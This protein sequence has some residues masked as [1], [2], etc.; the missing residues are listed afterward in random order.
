MQ[1]V[2]PDV[3]GRTGHVLDKMTHI[4]S[5]GD[6]CEQCVH[7]P[8]MVEYPDASG[9][10]VWTFLSLLAPMCGGLEARPQPLLEGLR[11]NSRPE[12]RSSTHRY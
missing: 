3:P 9:P 10:R 8:Y 5:T 12:I 11:I 2:L 1:A 4:P 7:W 6:F